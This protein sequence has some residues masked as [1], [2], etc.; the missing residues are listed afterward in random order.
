MVRTTM[1]DLARP[2][3]L[4]RGAPRYQAARGVQQSR[5]LAEVLASTGYARQYAIRLLQ[6]PAHAPL[7]TPI[8]PRD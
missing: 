7:R 6:S 3:L 1:S 4:V 5:I 8:D 2:E